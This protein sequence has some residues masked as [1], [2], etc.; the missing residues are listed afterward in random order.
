MT[1]T[2]RMTISSL[3]PEVG[4]MYIFFINEDLPGLGSARY[5]GTRGVERGKTSQPCH[6][7]SP[8]NI[9]GG[10]EQVQVML[11]CTFF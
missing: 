5:R 3:E 6:L 9:G 2:Y 7:P 10:D 4:S 11:H 8:D 1:S